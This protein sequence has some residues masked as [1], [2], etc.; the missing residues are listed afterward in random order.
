MVTVSGYH[1]GSLSHDSALGRPAREALQSPKSGAPRAST[2]KHSLAFHAYSIW[3]FTRSDLKT[4]VGPATAFGLA[5]ALAASSYG[6]PPA[7]IQSRTL[8]SLSV[9]ALTVAFKVWINLLPSVI[10]NQRQPSAIAED[11]INKPWRTLPSGRL[12]PEQA[13][14][15]MLVTYPMAA[16]TSYLVGGHRQSMMLLILAIWYNDLGG[17]DCHPII[18]NMINASGYLCFTSGAMETA[19]G[20]SLP[21]ARSLV[22]WFLIVGA[23]T[24]STIQTQDMHDQNGD[25]LRGRR[26]LPLE[27][28]DAPTR[29]ITA[30]MVSFWSWGCPLFWSVPKLYYT[31]TLLCGT[32]LVFRTLTR[33]SVSDDKFTFKVWNLWMVFVF[34]LPLVHRFCVG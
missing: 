11:A 21:P 33:R 18:R 31:P 9:R 25:R 29:W 20:Y 24:F 26:T 7:I 4:I 8:S 22:R 19:L 14:K 16:L 28:G 3:L 13:K 17:A 5:N 30:I 10:G 34:L 6:L 27:I 1:I 2:R 12:T 15:V 32:V 23:V